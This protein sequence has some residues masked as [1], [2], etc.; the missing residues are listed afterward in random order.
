MITCEGRNDALS[1]HPQN[2]TIVMA[3]K[4]GSFVFYSKTHFQPISDLKHLR[5]LIK[6]IYNHEKR[7]Q[8]H[9]KTRNPS[10]T[11]TFLG[12]YLIF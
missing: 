4:T 10:E 5:N 6:S 9:P 3:G 8:T 12:S 2:P 11:K 7:K 1:I